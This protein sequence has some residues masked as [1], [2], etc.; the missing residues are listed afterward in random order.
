MVMYLDGAVAGW[1]VAVVDEPLVSYVRHPGQISAREIRFREDLARLLE[2]YC[3][4]DRATERLRRR[5]A[6][7]AWL[8]VARAQ[9]KAG[10]TPAVRA[11]VARADATLRAPRVRAEALALTALSERPRLL[12]AVLRAWYALRGTPPTSET[13]PRQ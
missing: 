7:S 13:L 5:R 4:D 1:G 9:L 11:S 8:S 3:F 6:T 10:D 2:L 12:R